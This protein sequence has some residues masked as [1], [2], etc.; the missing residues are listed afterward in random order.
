MKLKKHLSEWARRQKLIGGIYFTKKWRAETLRPGL[1]LDNFKPQLKVVSSSASPGW[2]VF[3]LG[4]G[5]RGFLKALVN[6]YEI[7][8][9]YV[10]SS[11]AII[12]ILSSHL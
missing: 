9:M 8:P 2:T 4:G 1:E 11:L 6:I 7:A 10:A 3:V 5:E 12:F